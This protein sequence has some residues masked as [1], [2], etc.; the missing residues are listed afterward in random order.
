MNIDIADTSRYSEK[1]EVYKKEAKSFAKAGFTQSLAEKVLGTTWLT[2]WDLYHLFCYGKKI[3]EKGT[4]LEVM[5]HKGDSLALV[6][7]AVK[8]ARKS[9]NFITIG[10]KVNEKF[11]E[12]TKSIPHLKIIELQAPIAKDQIENNSIDLLFLDGARTYE[13]VKRDIQD[14]W[15]KLKIDGIFLG[16]DY[17]NQS[18]HQGVVKA[19]NEI[20][21]SKLRVLKN[22]R[23]FVVK[24]EKS[25][26]ELKTKALVVQPSQTISK[27]PSQQI[28]GGLSE[29]KSVKYD[30]VIPYYHCQILTKGCIESVIRHSKDY[31]IIASADGS[32]SREIEI[33]SEALKFAG[34]YTHLINPINIGFPGNTNRGL[35]VTE[36][37]FIVVINNDVTVRADWLDYLENEFHQRGENCF[38]GI[39][40]SRVGAR[41]GNTS[42][43]NFPE[44]DYVGWS[45]IF[46]SKVCFDKVGLLDE[47]FKIGYYEDVDFGLR[48]KQLGIKCF[49]SS[50]PVAH[51]GGRSMNTL[52]PRELGHARNL[53]LAYLKRKW[54]LK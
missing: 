1:L 34:R 38:I 3:P 33:V 26:M 8:T 12:G 42:S 15:P 25:N 41:G 20:F 45:V 50:P 49:V 4:Y 9:I 40:G 48:A 11:R 51:A 23:I 14:Y 47:N 28:D 32:K 13:C 44:V 7:K 22:S 52:A 53:N 24:K 6:H 43:P 46:S 30:I 16:H 10:A 21:G 27:G 31:R 17:T 35:K 18:A 29:E 36:A 37:K 5:S 39:A 54:R 19:S 2:T